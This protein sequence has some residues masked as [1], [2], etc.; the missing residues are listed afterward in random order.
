MQKRKTL[1][2]PQAKVNNNNSHKLKVIDET[3]SP[4][5]GR[6][7]VITSPL[8]GTNI[9]TENKIAESGRIMEKIW[10]SGLSSL[11][12]IKDFYPKNCL[13][14]GFGGGSTLK[15]M[16]KFWP[17]I[18]VFG[19]DIDP[20]MVHLGEKY[21]GLEIK[22]VKIVFMDAFNLKSKNKYDLIC[23]D[24]FINDDIPQKFTTSKF[25][26]TVKNNTRKNGYVIFN[27]LYS[28]SHKNDSDVFID[29]LTK[30]FSKVI[31]T[32]SQKNLLLIC[33]K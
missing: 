13:I 27:R 33:K 21:L 28:V 11:T 1:K 20:I 9:I 7:L 10:T 29:V 12:K 4:V 22:N 19:I 16:R 18:R 32:N 14:L 8:L 26:K 6:L 23:V 2:S 30:I 15:A 24:L 31:L 25:L 17:D 5:N 3:Y